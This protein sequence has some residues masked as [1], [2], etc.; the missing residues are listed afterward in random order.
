MRTF[1]TTFDWI[2]TKTGLPI[3]PI[4]KPDKWVSD[5]LQNEL[6]EWFWPPQFYQT[7]LGVRFNY[8]NYNQVPRY[9]PPPYPNPVLIH[10]PTG[11][12]KNYFVVNSLSDVVNTVGG[13]VL[14]L[15][16]R[17]ALTLQQRIEADRKNGFP[18]YSQKVY[19]DC[20]L[21]GN[22]DII[23]YHQ[24]ISYIADPN[25]WTI[26]CVKAVVFDEA[27]FFLA[28]SSF[29]SDTS[30]ILQQL[31]KRFYYCKRIYMSATPEEVKPILSYEELNAFYNYI[32]FGNRLI[33][34]YHD[35]N[36]KDNPLFMLRLSVGSPTQASKAQ[37]SSPDSKDSKGKEAS[38]DNLDDKTLSDSQEK[39]EIQPFPLPPPPYPC[40]A[41]YVFQGTFNHVNL[42]FFHSWYSIETTARDE[43]LPDKWLIFVRTKKDGEKLKEKIG[44]CAEFIDADRKKEDNERFQALIRDE[45]FDYK[46]LIST[47]VLYN[48]VS[49][50]DDALKHIVVDS[51]NKTEVIQMLGRKRC[52]EDESVNLY[53][54][55]PPIEELEERQ[56]EADTML[57]YMNQYLNDPNH[58]F[59]HKWEAD[60]FDLRLTKPSRFLYGKFYVSAYAPILFAQEAGNYARIIKTLKKFREPFTLEKEICGWFNKTFCK[61]MLY[62]ETAQQ[63]EERIK[64]EVIEYLELLRKKEPIELSQGE[65]ILSNLIE[66]ITPIKGKVEATPLKNGATKGKPRKLGADPQKVKADINRI[67]KFT[68]WPYVLSKADSVYTF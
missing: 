38:N 61:E 2:K 53:V 49:L 4:L 19:E 18:C 3:Q 30:F 42:H 63:A 22:M 59:E 67:I 25:N 55:I 46:V 5:G 60:F 21:S 12:G 7:D 29:N 37:E 23:S 65:T 35:L 62:G 17:T 50:K 40:F 34:E 9:N 27:H 11:S 32:Y 52:K 64:G 24:A 66:I 13:R 48:G 39:A 47:T 33:N 54:H 45:E 56:E 28:D 57:E 10:A 26:P 20:Y 6:R 1:P 15:T 36:P 58:L 68:S 16:N 51:V 8:V 31:I 14:I 43:T 44:D 41:E